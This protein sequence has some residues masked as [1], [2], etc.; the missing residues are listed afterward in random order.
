[1]GSLELRLEAAKSGGLPGPAAAAGHHGALLL[2]VWPA[3]GQALVPAF[4]LLWLL[5]FIVQAQEAQ[6]PREGYA[7]LP[8]LSQCCHRNLGASASAM[9]SAKLLACLRTLHSTYNFY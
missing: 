9:V 4:S 8:S 7:M 1:M 5:G 3:A 2:S 6:P